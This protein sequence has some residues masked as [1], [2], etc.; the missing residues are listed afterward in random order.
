MRDYPG[1]IKRMFREYKIE[2][3]EVELHRELSKVDKYFE[4][5]KNG[6][7][8]GGELSYRLHQY[9][10]GPSR[11]LYKKYNYGEDVTNVAYAIVTGMLDREKMPGELLEEIDGT[12]KNF[13]SMK[14]KGELREPDEE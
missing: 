2:A 12:L 14:D 3:Y 9:E 4:E 5:W 11:E 13:Q 8:S 6:T 7:I 10:I 1:N